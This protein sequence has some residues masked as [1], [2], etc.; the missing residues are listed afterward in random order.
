MSIE[1]SFEKR[2]PKIQTSKTNLGWADGWQYSFYFADGDRTNGDAQVIF[3]PLASLADHLRAPLL[4]KGLA[5]TDLLVHLNEF[6]PNGRALDE[7]EGAHMREGVGTEVLNL[8][9]EEARARGARGMYVFTGKTSMTSFL[10]KHG[11]ESLVG[12][13]KNQIFFKMI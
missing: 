10:A 2:P 4:T 6:Y 9:I 11:F 3:A 12:T 1:D 13:G 7:S 8:L 5:D